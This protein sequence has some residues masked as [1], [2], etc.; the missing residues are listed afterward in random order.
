MRFSAYIRTSSEDQVGNFSI[1][2]QKRSLQQWVKDQDGELIQI[3][4]DEGQSGLTINRPAFQQMRRDGKQGLF[5]A[6]IVYK[7][8]RFSR[9]RTDSLA[10]KSLLRQDY[11][12]KVFSVTEPSA[13]SDGAL[14]ALI[15]GLM[16]SL[17]DWY[18]QNLSH[19]TTKGKRER[20]MQ[21]YHNNRPPF[22]MDKTPEGVLYPNEDELEGL[23]L[24]FQLYATGDHSDNNVAHELNGRGFRSKTG[25]RFSTDTVRDMLQN[26][27]YLG[28]VKYQ[29]YARHADGS[30]SMENPVEWFNGRHDPI[31]PQDLFDQCKEAR[32]LR[33][34]S[35]RG[36][37]AKNRIYLLRDIIFC[38]QCIE[39][40]S[41][42][43]VDD[44]FGKMRPLGLTD[45][46][47]YRC[48]ACDLG[49][50]CN[51]KSIRIGDVERQVIHFLKTLQLPP[52][53]Q[54]PMATRIG[55]LIE[56]KNTDYRINEIKQ[57][58][59]RMDFRWDHGFIMDKDT[60][61]EQRVQLQ[62]ELEDLSPMQQ[63]ELEIATDI[64]ENFSA[65]WEAIGQDRSQQERLLKLIVKRVWVRDDQ[66]SG[67]L[68]QPD[69][70]V[71]LEDENTRL[72]DKR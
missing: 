65:H 51:Q 54:A 11:G 10:I 35:R 12:I 47:Y 43:L 15:E 13:D 68:L 36:H 6:L 34:H 31:I 41:L 45:S 53:W 23:L 7:F 42:D 22:G 32:A 40:K 44:N 39:N 71:D 55:Q 49:Y 69:F 56:S 26:R 30:R 61:L 3:Y 1:E 64:L 17:A 62:Q 29:K 24:A 46:A 16:S 27:T 33:T 66:I 19:E 21:G 72:Q 57:V 37:Y 58:I 18:S 4:I 59:D 20:A 2:A 38:V 50:E 48:R 67:I 5:D 63:D 14:G 9:N 52:N 70:Y 8:D 28:Y 25:K 60:Y